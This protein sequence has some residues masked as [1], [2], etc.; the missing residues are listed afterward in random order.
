MLSKKTKYA[1][2]ALRILARQPHSEP[3]LISEIAQQGDIPKKFLELILLELKKHHILD[4]KKGQ[5]GGYFLKLSPD[6]INLGE[7]IRK[8]SGPLGLVSCVNKDGYLPCDE[9]P[10]ED[11]CG[12]RE[13][14]ADVLTATCEILDH[15]M[16]AD[17]LVREERLLQQ[18]R[19]YMFHI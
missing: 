6:K 9:C 4:S 18:K 14:M 5:G 2:G 7:V 12:L 1:I 8:L 3:M 17:L 15:E 10:G 11:L 13:V 19:D 16:L